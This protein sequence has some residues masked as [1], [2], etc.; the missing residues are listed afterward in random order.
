M[1]TVKVYRIV[2]NVD[3]V[4]YIGSTQQ[5]LHKRMWAHKSRSNK[6]SSKQLFDNYGAEN[7]S[8]ILIA[9]VLVENREQQLRTERDYIEQYRDT[10]V[11][12]KR[13]FVTK[14][15][16]KTSQKEHY[17][18][19]KEDL[20]IK[21]K[22]YNTLNKEDLS[23]KRKEY[24]TSNKEDISIKHKEYY[25]LNKEKIKLR[26]SETIECDI[27]GKF[28]TKCYMLKHKKNVHI[29]FSYK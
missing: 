25:T 3:D 22:E 21:Q 15:E 10:C 6:C 8:I 7:C 4:C 2:N 18:L 26:S 23:I 20:L 19:N 24:Y 17:T 27:C 28:I 12:I 9:E 11:N 1:N 29:E 5:P 16:I 14:E 13:P